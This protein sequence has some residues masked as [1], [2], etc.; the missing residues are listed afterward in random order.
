MTA[1]RLTL[2]HCGASRTCR[3]YVPEGLASRP[4]LAVM[5]QPTVGSGDDFARLTRFD[6][7]AERMGWVGAYLESEPHRQHVGHD[8]L[9]WCSVVRAPASEPGSS[10]G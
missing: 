2:E 6:G 4:G 10:S 9:R 3:V 8:G 5:L 7:Q 1:V